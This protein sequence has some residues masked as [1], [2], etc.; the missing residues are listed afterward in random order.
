M[1]TIAWRSGKRTFTILLVSVALAAVGCFYRPSSLSIDSTPA[2]P[3]EA[4]VIGRVRVV[5]FKGGEMW[6]HGTE[7]FE[8]FVYRDGVEK[9][10]YHSLTEDGSFAWHLFPGQYTIIG[11]YM[12]GPSLFVQEPLRV[13]FVIPEGNPFV[14][15][16]TLRLQFMSTTMMPEVSVEDDYQAAVNA[17]RT[18]HRAS[19]DVVKILMVVE[20]P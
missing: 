11:F 16:G 15:I 2:T 17:F 12:R 19:A 13:D 3:G 7:W 5:L 8:V 1:S 9:A 4:V 14:Y 6:W 10:A 18:Q 20:R